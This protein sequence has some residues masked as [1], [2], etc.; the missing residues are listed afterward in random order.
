MNALEG[1]RNSHG[2]TL[3][4]KYEDLHRDTIGEMDRLIR[5]IDIQVTYEVLEKAVEFAAFENMHDMERRGQFAEK[6]SE[7]HDKLSPSLGYG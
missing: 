6:N 4:I 1:W 2:N 3:I 7:I 5:F